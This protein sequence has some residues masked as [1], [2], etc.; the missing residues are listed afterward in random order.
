MT[1]PAIL[2]SSTATMN[3]ITELAVADPVFAISYLLYADPSSFD[4]WTDWANDSVNSP[5]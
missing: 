2:L 5:T 1:E 4:N 3:V